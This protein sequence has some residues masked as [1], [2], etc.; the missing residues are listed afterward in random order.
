MDIIFTAPEGTVSMDIAF[1]AQHIGQIA[2]FKNVQISEY[3]RVNPVT[4][5]SAVQ[6]TYDKDTTV[7]GTLATAKKLGYDFKGWFTGKNG[8]GTQITAQTPTA[9]Y[10]KKFTAWSN[11]EEIQ[12]TVTYDAAGGTLANGTVNPTKYTINTAKVTA[13]AAPSKK[14]Y[15]FKG[16]AVTKVNTAVHADNNWTE[17]TVAAGNEFTGKLYGDVK[18]T[19]V[20]EENASNVVVVLREQNADGSYTETGIINGKK[21]DG[22]VIDL[23]AQVAAKTGFKAA[24][25]TNNGSAFTLSNGKFT[26]AGGKNYNIIITRDRE[27]YTFSVQY[28]MS[29]GTTAPAGVTKTLY[30]GQ[31]ASVTSPD[32]TGYTPDKKIATVN[33]ISANTTVTVTYTL[34]TYN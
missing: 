13:A 24:A 33:A 1:G 7:F 17:A 31:S 4:D 9:S 23:C 18:L 21:L 32:K 28:K 5:Y 12:Y 20:W 19:A 10:H 15:T 25:V 30:Y 27:T 16:W 6:K 14:G 11:W 26:V 2:S 8:T 34:N 22:D 29:D 3:D